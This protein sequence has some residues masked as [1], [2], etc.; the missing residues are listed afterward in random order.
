MPSKTSTKA[1]KVVA[2]PVEK[3]VKP[4]KTAKAPKEQKATATSMDELLSLG[5]VHPPKKGSIIDAKIIDISKKGIVFDIGWKSYAVLGSLEAQEL[6]TYMPY[7]K[8]GDTTPVKVVVEEAKEGFPVVSMRSFFEKGKW[9]ILEEKQ[10]NEEEIEVVAG[11]YGKGG[12]FIEF[13]GIRGFIHK[14]KL[15]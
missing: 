1:K 11:E 5:T 14:L 15:T 6:P 13:M 7:L 8:L 9:D 10:K 3:S 12:V 4:P 2:S